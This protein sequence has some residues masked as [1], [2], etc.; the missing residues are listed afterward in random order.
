MSFRGAPKRGVVIPEEYLYFEKSRCSTPPLLFGM[1]TTQH[2][3][4]S[5]RRTNIRSG[6]R[7]N[8][9]TRGRQNQGKY[10]TIASRSRALWGGRR[11]I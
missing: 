4:G 5:G 8:S 6:N 1:S 2:R 7:R 3:Y 10:M 11:R 9:I